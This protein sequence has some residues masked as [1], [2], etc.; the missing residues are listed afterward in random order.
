[1]AVFPCVAW[2]KLNV[3]GVQNRDSLISP[4]GWFFLARGISV[5]KTFAL[6]CLFVPDNPEHTRIWQHL[7]NPYPL[8]PFFA[9]MVKNVMEPPKEQARTLSLSFLS[10]RAALK[11]TNLRGQTFCG[12]LRNSAVFFENQ[13]F[14]F[15]F[16][17]LRCENLRKCLVCPLRNVCPLKRALIYLDIFLFVVGGAEGKRPNKKWWLSFLAEP[18][19]LEAPMPTQT[20]K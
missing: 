13:R 8:L 11:G 19:R 3:A 6:G 15:C 7:R 5:P 14:F 1:M 16:L 2:E 18:P 4:Q 9:L 17:L 12:F 20:Q 10:L